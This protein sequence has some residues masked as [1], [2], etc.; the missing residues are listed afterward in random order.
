MK[1]FWIQYCKDFK[2]NFSGL[3][4]YFIFAIYCLFSFV[5]SIYFANYYIRENDVVLSYFIFQPSILAL[6]IPAITMRS[7][8]DELRNGT[9]ELIITQPISYTKLV[10]SKFF[11]SYSF[12]VLLVLSSV[13]FMFISSYFSV[14]DTQLTICNYVGLLLCSAL[15][16]AIGCLISI[17]NK[18]NILSYSI[19]I[20]VLFFIVNFSCTS[21]ANIS[22]ECL[23]FEYNYNA[24]LSGL[25]YWCNF[26][27]FVVCTILLLW[28]NILVIKYK[29]T[30]I[31]KEKKLFWIFVVIIYCLG[32]FSIE[33]FYLIDD[34]AFDITTDKRYTLSEKTKNFLSNTDK[35]IDVVLYEAKSQRED[36]NSGYAN[37]AEFVERFFKR[38]ERES[39]GAVRLQIVKI[40]GFSELERAIVND[41]IPYSEDKFGN[42]IY[43]FADF[44]DNEGNSYKIKSFTPSRQNLL[45]SDI[46]RVLN[47]F[48]KGKKNI[49]IIA[50]NSQLYDINTFKNVLD[51]FY[52]AAYYNITISRIPDEYDGV[53]IINP[54]YYPLELLIAIDQYVLNGGNLIIFG[55]PDDLGK[56]INAHLF[57]LLKNYGIQSVPSS[58]LNTNPNGEFSSIGIASATNEYQNG[59]SILINGAGRFEIKSYGKYDIN[60]ILK[61]N[62]NII[63]AKTE[64]IFVSEYFDR[65]EEGLH[66]I[67]HSKN[68]GKVF[69]FSDADLLRNYLYVSDES[70]GYDF[71]QAVTFSDNLL[72]LLQLLDDATGN[73]I[74]KLLTYNVYET[75]SASIGGR[76]YNIIKKKYQEKIEKASNELIFYNNKKEKFYNELDRQGF[77]SVKS[78]EDMGNID[79]KIDNALIELNKTSATILKEY[80]AI[81]IC[82]SILIIFIIPILLLIM[83]A[84]VIALYKRRK[85]HKIR[86][87][88]DNA[89][90]Y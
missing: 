48:E 71:Y 22:I 16:T 38:L 65:N 10:L 21:L 37:Y 54:S 52:N 82:I 3:N 61:I 76:I 88:M 44:S 17:L 12:A 84:I 49:A 5:A 9:I 80:E 41:K 77:V 28:V 15:F 86:R 20:L 67:T 7:W 43:L 19:T 2:N 57:S 72:F 68:K 42:K 26:I 39:M 32:A 27:Y 1:Q 24:F 34:N 56:E 69:F 62:D 64:G 60:P 11:S 25:L 8:G 45:E 36:T 31:K 6:I 66:F 51:E 4:A 81:I 40:E 89:K 33:S 50:E 58:I 47:L 46:L 29:K 13:P 90:A 59:N 83:M 79:Q 55:E 18:N 35:R 14:I 23:N 73:N 63:G 87:L 78:I 85:L 75:N 74:E 70:K 30:T 53:V